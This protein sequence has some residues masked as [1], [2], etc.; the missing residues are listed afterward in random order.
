MCEE[1]D[2]MY[3][4]IAAIVLEKLLKSLQL[5]LLKLH[6]NQACHHLQ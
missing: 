5:L 6:S 1:G 2:S 3:S 4:I